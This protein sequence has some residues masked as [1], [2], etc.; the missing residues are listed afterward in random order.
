MAE[1]AETPRVPDLSLVSVSL[2]KGVVYKEKDADL[3]S[4][5]LKLHSAARDY[6]RVLGLDL[7]VDEVEGYAF[8]RSHKSEDEEADGVPRLMARRQL[9]FPV[10]LLLALLRKK[11]AEFDA[12]GGSTRLILSLDEVVEMVRVFSPETSNE[13]RATDAVEGHMKKIEEMGFV[14]RVRA[15]GG[16]NR[17]DAGYSVGRILAAFVDAQWLAEFDERL[18][19]YQDHITGN[20]QDAGAQ[21]GEVDLE[22]KANE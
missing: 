7:E 19:A 11:L 22:G 12:T 1:F 16:S 14:K 5:M 18:A 21:E 20:R 10:S 17:K 4:A 13:A 9:S 8:L 3:W 2:L 6:F 15:I